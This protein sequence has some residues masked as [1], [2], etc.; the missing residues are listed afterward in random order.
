MNQNL[1]LRLKNTPGQWRVVPEDRAF[2]LET[3]AQAAREAQAGY[4]PCLLFSFFTAQRVKR[5][6]FLCEQSRSFSAAEILA[7]SGQDLA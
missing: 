2:V 4:E 6:G 7:Y 3:L 1:N 5:N